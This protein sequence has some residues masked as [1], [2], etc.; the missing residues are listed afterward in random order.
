MGTAKSST[1]KQYR[2]HKQYCR[3]GVARTTTDTNWM[4][5]ETAR[6]GRNLTPPTAP[7]LN[8]VMKRQVSNGLNWGWKVNQVDSTSTHN[9]C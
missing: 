4:T 9:D 3:L 6:P 2:T 7:M 5:Q 8:S 1:Y